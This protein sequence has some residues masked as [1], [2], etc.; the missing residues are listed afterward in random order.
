MA[1]CPPTK[2]FPPAGTRGGI[3]F[4]NLR[5]SLKMSK[6]PDEPIVKKT[7]RVNPEKL[8]RLR[9]LIGADND[10]EAIR[11]VIDE[12]LAYGEALSA[13]RRLQKRG[14]F[15]REAGEGT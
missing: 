13:A 3:K 9:V 15:G 4:I 6:T 1:P 10:S 12:A 2:S 5:R 7:L 11:Q 14:S 8:A